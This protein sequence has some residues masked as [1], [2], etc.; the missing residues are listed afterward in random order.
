[1]EEI[2]RVIIFSKRFPSALATRSNQEQQPGLQIRQAVS[3]E[4]GTI[5]KKASSFSNL[6]ARSHSGHDQVRG[7]D[8]RG[9]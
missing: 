9:L 7:N 4:L 6:S 1:M 5:G 8:I 2:I 3:D